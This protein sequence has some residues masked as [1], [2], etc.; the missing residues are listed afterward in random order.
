MANSNGHGGRRENTGGARE[1]AGRPKNVADV[2]LS[3]ARIVSHAQKWKLAE[4]AVEFAEEAFHG[5]VTLMRSAE[6]ETVR[7]DA[8][9]EILDRTFGKSPQHVDIAAVKHTEIVYRS[10]QEIRQELIARGVPQVLL[11][12]DKNSDKP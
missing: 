10:A 4:M 9:K 1:G 3:P 6:N 8:M 12:Y 11:D 7:L 5:L 2:T